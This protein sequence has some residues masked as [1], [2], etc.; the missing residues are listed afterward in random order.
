MGGRNRDGRKKKKTFWF[1]RF[2]PED[3]GA[4]WAQNGTKSAGGTSR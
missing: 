4:Q 3:R 1:K 2:A